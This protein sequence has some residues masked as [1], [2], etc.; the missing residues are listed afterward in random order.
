MKIIR[1]NELTEN[2]FKYLEIEEIA[3][4][5]EIITDVRQN[6]DRAVKNYSEKFDNVILESIKVSNEEI[7]TAS[8]NLTQKE[9]ET[10]KFAAEN[11]RNFANKQKENFKDFEYEIQPGVF[12]G[13]KVVPIKRVGVYAPGGSYP[14]P[15]TVLMCAIPALVAGSEEIVLCSPPTNN[16]S[17]HPA[18]LVAAEICQIKEVYQIGGVQAIAAMAY[19]TETIKPVDKIVGPGNKYVTAAK[20]EV[21]GT[22]GIDFIAGPTEVL[23]FADATAN[24]E[25][26]AA[27]LLAQAE[28]D[29]NAIPILVTDSRQLAL[30]VTGEVKNQLD[31]LKTADIAQVS[32]EQNGKIILVDSLDEAVEISNKKAPEHL[33]LQVKERDKYINRLKNYGSL[34]IGSLAAEVLG[35]YSSGLNHTLPTNTTARYTGGLSVKDFLKIQTTL[36][37][38]KE[39]L[40]LIGPVAEE[41]G[42]MEGLAG[43]AES[44]ARRLK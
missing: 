41:L 36:R 31:K 32:I 14:L 39:G 22:V 38:E 4:V 29:F 23:I 43:H 15:S 40:Q 30:Q 12:T 27:D 35:D 18:I 8:S 28:H 1:A 7:S 42:K 37:L 11:I 13:Q 44:I 9:I 2:F 20:K 19:G 6:G 24:P 5:K 10:L 26:I 34:F 21:F 25:F 33:E 3:S 17:I 16:G